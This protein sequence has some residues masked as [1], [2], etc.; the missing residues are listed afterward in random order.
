MTPM[1]RF[2]DVLDRQVERRTVDAAQAAAACAQTRRQIDRLGALSARVQLVPGTDAVLR[3]NAA[4]FREQLLE[5]AAQCR[6]ELGAQESQR[7]AAQIALLAA[8]QRQQVVATVLRRDQARAALAERR[9]EQKLQDEMAGRAR[10]ARERITPE[11]TH[12]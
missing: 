4:G 3:A 9:G 2:A 6:D 12:G 7:S 5:A 8:V 10:G 1:A 11:V